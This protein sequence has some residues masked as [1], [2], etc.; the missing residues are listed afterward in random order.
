MTNSQKQSEQCAKLA[1]SDKLLTPH[2]DFALIDGLVRN[3]GGTYTHE[4]LYDCAVSFIEELV[5]INK[6]QAYIN[7]RAAEIQRELNK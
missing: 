5:I 7:S 2:G 3:Y 6:K 1:G 4:Y